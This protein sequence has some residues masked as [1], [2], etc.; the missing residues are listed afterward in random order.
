M[1]F[2]EFIHHVFVVLWPAKTLTRFAYR[3]M[4][5]KNLLHINSADSH[6][7]RNIANVVSLHLLKSFDVEMMVLTTNF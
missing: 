7:I 6:A 5:V 2:F 1:F 4:L 3:V